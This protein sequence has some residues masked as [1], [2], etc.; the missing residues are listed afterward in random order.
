MKD[1]QNRFQSCFSGH[2]EAFLAHKRALGNDF[3]TE[4]RGLRL[5][6]RYLVKEHV[7]SIEEITSQ[8]LDSFLAS[9]PRL[10][11]RSYNHLLG[12]LRRLFKWLVLHEVILHSPLSAQPKRNTPLRKPF[13]FDK[14]LA[15]RLLEAAVYLPDR[16]NCR[17]RGETYRMIFAML[18]GLGLRVG[19]VTRLCRK[20]LDFDRQLVVIYQTKFYKSRLVPFGPRMYARLCEYLQ[21]RESNFG[22]LQPDHSVFSFA[23]DSRK[24]INPTTIS[25]TFHKLV[26]TLN[27]SIPTGVTPPHLHCLRHS[28]AVGTLLRWYKAGVDP[29]Q[30][31]FF[32]STFLGHVSPSS[33]AVYLTITKELLQEGCKRFEEFVAPILL[34]A[35][36]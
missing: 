20:D 12:C 18:Y 6:D 17:L 25:W 28:F 32:L 1:K 15:R 31:L 27:F 8:M 10:S 4:E 7:E 5:L 33:T 26:T 16:P 34:E 22:I 23:K 14:T 13:L 19:E 36:K 11:S 35:K 3:S 9:R 21:K 24:Q 30:R 2:I 29:S